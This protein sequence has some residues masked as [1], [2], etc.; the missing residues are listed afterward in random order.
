MLNRSV[1]PVLAAG[2]GHQAQT[3]WA[4]GTS[5]PPS[6][7]PAVS[8]G[9][10]RHRQRGNWPEPE[11]FVHERAQDGK[12]VSVAV[13]GVTALQH[14]A[15]LLVDFGLNLRGSERDD[16][17][18][19]KAC[20]FVGS[21]HGRGGGVRASGLCRRKATVQFSQAAVVSVPPMRRSTVA[22]WTCTPVST[23][24]HWEF[25]PG[26]V[27]T[28]SWP[29]QGT[30]AL[31]WKTV[32][33]TAWR[34][35]WCL[36]MA[37]RREPVIT[38]VLVLSCDCTQHK[39]QMGWEERQPPQLSRESPSG[40]WAAPGTGWDASGWAHLSW[41][42]PSGDE[43]TRDW[44]ISCPKQTTQDKLSWCRQH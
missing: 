10:V 4:D 30:N 44:G 21:R 22:M 17:I 39:T 11:D 38:S 7:S 23:W 14:R 32:D 41:S 19:P 3:G 18:Q 16:Q 1:R 35:L 6:V 12:P 40:G 33:L 43:K 5:P 25:S 42:P 36:P 2:A 24:R 26:N 29:Y 13:F 9:F 20:M 27:S 37:S 8:D 31:R 34:S 28:S 15:E